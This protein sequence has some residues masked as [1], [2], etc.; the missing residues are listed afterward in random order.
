MGNVNFY[1]LQKYICFTASLKLFVE[2]FLALS[3][4]GYHTHIVHEY[5]SS[6][7]KA[8]ILVGSSFS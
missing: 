1:Q 2:I 6:V 7:K 3:I 8:R 5:C 4:A